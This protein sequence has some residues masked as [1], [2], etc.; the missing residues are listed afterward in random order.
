MQCFYCN[1]FGHFDYECRMKQENEG[2]TKNYG[3]EHGYGEEQLFLSM[4]D[5]QKLED[6]T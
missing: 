6:E 2:N 4:T 5:S 1:K 3:E